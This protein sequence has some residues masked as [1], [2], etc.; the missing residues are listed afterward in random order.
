MP[1]R[2]AAVAVRVPHRSIRD[3]GFCLIDGTLSGDR[4]AAGFWGSDRSKITWG[5]NGELETRRVG[6]IYRGN[7]AT[8]GERIGQSEQ[9]SRQGRRAAARLDTAWKHMGPAPQPEDEHDANRFA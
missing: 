5:L 6:L 9:P 1:R 2:R 8:R 3:L 4:F 7:E